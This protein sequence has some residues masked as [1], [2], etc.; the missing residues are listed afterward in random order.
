L[1]VSLYSTPAVVYD[2]IGLGIDAF[3]TQTSGF[4]PDYFTFRDGFIGKISPDDPAHFIASLTINT[5]A[6][7]DAK[8]AAAFEHFQGTPYA[9]GYPNC[10]AAVAT[11]LRAGGLQFQFDIRPGFLFRN[12]Q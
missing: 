8:I 6:Q 7:Q 3:P 11:A 5:S 9:L 2:H 12:L 4:R 10:A 1:T